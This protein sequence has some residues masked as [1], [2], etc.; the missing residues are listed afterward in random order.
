M[1]YDCWVKV[2]LWVLCQESNKESKNCRHTHQSHITPSNHNTT[3]NGCMWSSSQA[4]MFRYIP[5]MATHSL[6]TRN[7]L[8]KSCDWVL[9]AA[10]TPNSPWHQLFRRGGW[11]EDVTDVCRKQ[12]DWK[13][14]KAVIEREERGILPSPLPSS[15]Q[16]RLNPALLVVR[17][18]QD[19]L[20]ATSQVKLPNQTVKVSHVLYLNTIT[21]R[22]WT[23]NPLKPDQRCVY[24]QKELIRAA[25]YMTTACNPIKEYSTSI[26]REICL[27]LV[28]MYCNVLHPHTFLWGKWLTS[29]DT[30]RRHQHK[31]III[32]NSC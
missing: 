22:L 32:L 15:P 20:A 5:Y 27:F 4:L 26:H 28:W 29:G 6:I 23:D 21:W 13:G 1:Q 17:M 25:V 8:Q 7:Q 16:A 10:Q 12:W 24:V 31:K 3:L 2:G 11:L 30:I 19:R 18:G 14:R 9:G